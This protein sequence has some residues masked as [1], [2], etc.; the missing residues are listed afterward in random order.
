MR[1][2]KRVTDPL[3]RYII[4]SVM[5]SS[6]SSPAMNREQRPTGSKRAINAAIQLLH[7]RWVMRILWELRVGPMTFRMLQHACGDLSPTVIN[8]RLKTLRKARLLTHEADEGYRLSGT[9]LEL[10]VAMK[11]L[12]AWAVRWHQAGATMTGRATRR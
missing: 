8:A 2:N 9:G 12:M 10:L 5:P 3:Y 7:L 6:A 11:P 4:R 1:P